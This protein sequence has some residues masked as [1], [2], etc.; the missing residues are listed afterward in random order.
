MALLVT[1]A[2]GYVG[3]HV[4][5]VLPEGLR[6][7]CL[8]PSIEELDLADA[9]AVRSFFEGY[10]VSQ[11]LHLAAVIDN[12]AK[13]ELLRSSLTG[14]YNLARMSREFG[15]GHFVFAS[16]NNVYGDRLEAAPIREEEKG[17]PCY[18]NDYG[19]TKYAGELLVRDVFEGS[20]T[21]L[22]IVR[23][24]DI[25]G[26]GQKE[27][28]LVKA[29]VANVLEGRPQRLYGAGERVRDYV[30]IDDVARGFV[31][32]LEGRL[33]GVYN[34]GTG[35]GTSVREI[36]EMAEGLSACREKTVEVAVEQEDRGKVVLDVSKLAATGFR[37]EVGFE[38]GLKRILR[39]EL[40]GKLEGNLEGK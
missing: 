36:V 27:G 33:A 18:G 35:V 23:I 14:L 6:E 5:Q 39:G 28:K 9:G 4:M 38:E 25:F 11:V 1:G 12:G 24:G 22:A 2:A 34:L 31:H 20:G 19:L 8:T 17:S 15:V 29:V 10:S 13:A 37:A 40:G 21:A 16:T 30:Y 32:V 3:S 26:P 7:G